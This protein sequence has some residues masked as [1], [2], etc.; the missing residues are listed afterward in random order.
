M[1]FTVIFFEFT[2]YYYSL[3]MKIIIL[4]EIFQLLF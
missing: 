4:E 1:L 2:L 3:T